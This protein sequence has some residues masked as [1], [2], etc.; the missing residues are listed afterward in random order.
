M[1]GHY[2]TRRE[3]NTAI[4]AGAAVLVAGPASATQ[5]TEP[6]TLPPPRSTGGKPLIEALMLRRSTR[7]YSERPLPLQVLSDLLWAV[8]G[9]VAYDKLSRA[10]RI[11][12]MSV[13]DGHAR[14]GCR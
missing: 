6:I 4:L 8:F 7:E 14:R 10:M 5:E 2:V 3:A 12:T 1:R 11:R 13:R 9:A